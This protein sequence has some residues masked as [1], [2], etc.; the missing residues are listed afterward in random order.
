MMYRMHLA[1]KCPT[2]GKE[3]GYRD[4]LV[5]EDGDGAASREAKDR[6]GKRNQEGGLRFSIIHFE[7]IDQPE[8]TTPIDVE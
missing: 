7:R 2:C 1:M 6:I 4:E 8:K 3:Q 5:E